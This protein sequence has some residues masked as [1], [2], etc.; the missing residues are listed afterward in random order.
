M[1]E[2]EAIARGVI[3]REEV[4]FLSQYGTSYVLYDEQEDTFSYPIKSDM[5]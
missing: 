2:Q 1:T 4:P 3:R 5:Y